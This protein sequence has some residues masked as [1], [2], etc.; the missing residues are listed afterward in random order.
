MKKIKVY[1]MENCPYCTNL[2]DGLNKLDFDYEKID[3]DSEE[4]EK[5]FLKL[6]E[7]T[8]SDN[9]PIIIVGN[10][11]LLPEITFRTIDQA[12]KLIEELYL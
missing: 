10:D 5:E 1:Y 6:Y 7:F 3:V 9:I 11:V 8:K 4:G 12:L 2:M